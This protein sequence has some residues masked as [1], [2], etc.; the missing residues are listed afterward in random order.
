[1]TSRYGPLS[2]RPLVPVI[3]F[4][5]LE[6]VCVYI[7]IYVYICVYICVYMY[8]YMYMCI[9][10]SAIGSSNEAKLR[11]PNALIEE[12]A[13]NHTRCQGSV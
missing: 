4:D 9:H 6:Y 2:L 10:L 5:M 8:I 1:M 7:Y 3:G 13:S 11:E 12:H